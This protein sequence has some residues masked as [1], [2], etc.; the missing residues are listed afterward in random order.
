MRIKYTQCGIELLLIC[1]VLVFHL[2]HSPLKLLL[3]LP[4]VTDQSWNKLFRAHSS[5]YRSHD[6]SPGLSEFGV[7]E[8]HHF[9]LPLE[10]NCEVW[11]A[12]FTFFCSTPILSV[13]SLYLAWTWR[14]PWKL[15][16]SHFPSWKMGEVRNMVLVY[17]SNIWMWFQCEFSKSK[18][19]NNQ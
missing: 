5:C 9:H 3:L 12:I 19:I 16:W 7:W 14:E 6:S 18:K 1:Y 13:C 17:A 15:M 2:H 10:H 11:L 8:F 4:S